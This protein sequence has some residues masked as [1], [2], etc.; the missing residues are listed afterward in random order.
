MCAL[1]K[2]IIACTVF[3]S[4]HFNVFGFHDAISKIGRVKWNYTMYEENLWTRQ[5]ENNSLEQIYK[6]HS[7]FIA[8]VNNIYNDIDGFYPVIN[9]TSNEV[10]QIITIDSI[11]NNPYHVP[12]IESVIL[13]NANVHDFWVKFSNWT[14]FNDTVMFDNLIDD[15]IP[16]LQSAA[17]EFW[18]TSNT[19][20]FFDFLKNV[21]KFN[22]EFTDRVT[23]TIIIYFF[24]LFSIDSHRN[25]LLV[26][27]SD[28]MNYLRIN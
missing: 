17:K 19:N 9:I 10:T 1:I 27:I 20:I 2:L 11:I 6:D 8:I 28:N 18:N 23:T 5:Y 22:I 3:V 15:A 4:L 13:A 16:S 24:F 25:H 12:V 21:R 14:D 26:V 7:D